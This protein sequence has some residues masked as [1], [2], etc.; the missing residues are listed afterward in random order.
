MKGR[1]EKGTE[2]KKWRVGE[3]E[4]VMI[5]RGERTRNL[6]ST[7][8]KSKDRHGS[9]RQKS[10]H[11]SKSK[12]EELSTDDYFSKNNEFATWLKEEKKLFFSDLSS[13]YARELFSDFIKD[14]NDLK[15]ESRYYEG[16]SSGPRSAHNWKYALNVSK[17]FFN[18][19]NDL[20]TSPNPSPGQSSDSVSL[21]IVNNCPVTIWPI[22][23]SN[24][25]YTE[26]PV[27]SFTLEQGQST[28]LQVPGDWSGSIWGRT[29]CSQDASGNL[30]CETGD[31]NSS[32]VQWDGPRRALPI[33]LANFNLNHPGGQDLYEVNVADGYNL[34]I[35]IRPQ[36]GTGNVCVSTGCVQDLNSVCPPELKVVGDDGVTTVAC[37]NA[38]LAFGCCGDVGCV[39]SASGQFFKNACPRARTHL[40]EVT[41]NLFSCVDADYKIT[42]CPPNPFGDIH[43][44]R[45]E[46][47][48]RVTG[49]NIPI[50]SPTSQGT[51]RYSSTRNSIIHNAAIWMAMA[52]IWTRPYKSI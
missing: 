52:A 20:P 17:S 18:P 33:T 28:T 48:P 11:H 19:R 49:E 46:A 41:N 50:P 1:A 4:R 22:A 5:K 10:G 9:K 39:S 38:C 8:K 26:L 13:E 43:I 21:S 34:P 29:F 42:F 16:I 45:H 51:P 14:W 3:A 36:R 32:A 24:A 27:T 2:G 44:N 7:E 40:F 47:K 23:L 6:T 35:V 37:K 31:F 30:A 12:I 15:L 25:G